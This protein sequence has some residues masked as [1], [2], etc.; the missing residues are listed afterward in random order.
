M[1]IKIISQCLHN[2]AVIQDALSPLTYPFSLKYLQLFP[3]CLWIDHTLFLFQH[4]FS[5]YNISA[6]PQCGSIALLA[7]WIIQ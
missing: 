3:L 2:T 4:I 6:L 5:L 1:I 7:S